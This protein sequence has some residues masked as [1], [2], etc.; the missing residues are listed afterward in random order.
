MYD[1]HD[2]ISYRKKLE[3]ADEQL[4]GNEANCVWYI[5]PR[6]LCFSLYKDI[7]FIKVKLTLFFIVCPI[8]HLIESLLVAYNS[9]HFSE[10]RKTETSHISF[11]EYQGFIFWSRKHLEIC[12]KFKVTRSF[13]HCL[14][15]IRLYLWDSSWKIRIEELLK[16][17]KK[18]A[19]HV[20]IRKFNIFKMHCLA[21]PSYL[22]FDQNNNKNTQKRPFIWN[23]RKL[24]WSVYFFLSW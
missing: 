8:S 19:T 22:E 20:L 11:F 10:L 2:K 1:T 17:K 16:T 4:E 23:K 18:E 14:L 6:I 3:N 12:S 24:L 13:F 7:L 15:S 5:H 21:L 9:R